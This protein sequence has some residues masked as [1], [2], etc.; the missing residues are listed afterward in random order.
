M[1]AGL[2]GGE[3][4]ERAEDQ[5]SIE[6]ETGWMENRPRAAACVV[7]ET[8]RK[9]GL[10]LAGHR[11]AQATGRDRDREGQGRGE[12]KLSSVHGARAQ[13]NGGP[14]RSAQAITG[15]AT[16][17]RRAEPR[18]PAFFRAAPARGPRPKPRRRVPSL[19]CLGPN[20][21]PNNTAAARRRA[22]FWSYAESPSYQGGTASNVDNT[23][24]YSTQEAGRWILFS[25]APR[26]CSRARHVYA[27]PF[28]NAG[29]KME[30]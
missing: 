21:W 28:S 11:L 1:V 18:P 30:G 23:Y 29:K 15:T 6:R 20:P 2:G 13:S 22:A 26:H 17:T 24:N 27:W 5:G 25:G 10:G 8:T 7:A 16:G 4:S 19:S 3:R 12:E 9:A 14:A